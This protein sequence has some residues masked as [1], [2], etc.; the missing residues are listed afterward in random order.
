MPDPGTLRGSC[1]E[2]GGCSGEHEP[3]A[4]PRMCDASKKEGRGKN[5]TRPAR[6]REQEPPEAYAEAPNDLHASGPRSRPRSLSSRCSATST[7][8]RGTACSS[9]L[10]AL[11]HLV[12]TATGFGF[13]QHSASYCE[14]RLHETETKTKET[15]FQVHFSCGVLGL[16]GPGSDS[17]T[18]ATSEVAAGT[19]VPGQTLRPSVQNP[20]EHVPKAPSWHQKLFL[21]THQST[22]GSAQEER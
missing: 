9:S 10:T 6:G 4:L 11:L 15:Q 12:T 13:L 14:L 18:K 19:D 22:A 5:R 7:P 8:G 17:Q 3:Y 2:G 21:R 20:P 16:T 1:G